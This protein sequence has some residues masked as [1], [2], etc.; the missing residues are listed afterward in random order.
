MVDSNIKDRVLYEDNH[1][2]I[3]NKCIGEIV[4]ADKTCDETLDDILKQYIKIRDNKPGNVFIGVV[5]RIDRPVSGLVIFAKT[6]KALSRLNNMFRD[7]KIHKTYYAIIKNKPKV[8]EATLV[9]NL[10]RNKNINKSFVSGKPAN[11]TKE[12]KLHYKLI[13]RSDTYFLLEIELMTGRHHQI[14]CQLAAIGSPIKGDLKYGYPRSNANGGISLH[15]RKIAFIHPVSNNQIEITAPFPEN[16][17]WNRF[18]I[19]NNLIH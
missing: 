13:C 11:N 7:G 2:I 14:R 8:E 18:E 10:F 5:H 17:L 16:D 12:A 4:Q 1:I 15:A 3:V 6:S 9:N 19:Q